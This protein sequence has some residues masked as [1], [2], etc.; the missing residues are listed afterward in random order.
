MYRNVNTLEKIEQE[1]EEKQ[2]KIIKLNQLKKV[3][4]TK[5]KLATAFL[6]FSVFSVTVFGFF[7][8]LVGQAKLN[9]LTYKVSKDLDNLKDEQPVILEK[10][11]ERI[12]SISETYAIEDTAVI[13]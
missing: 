8:F 5:K 13:Y 6:G 7:Y 9:E 4:K 11:D 10:D 2:K 12:P 3:N 1:F